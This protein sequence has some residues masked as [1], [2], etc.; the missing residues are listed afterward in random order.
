VRPDA[1]DE[2]IQLLTQRLSPGLAG[3]LVLII[4]GLF[5]PTIAIIGYLAI[6]LFFILPF[7]PARWSSRLS[8]RRRRL[9]A[10]GDSR[11]A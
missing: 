11:Q 5:R 10:G 4:A 6:A 3:Y 8:R 7:R 2:E 9:A 1:A